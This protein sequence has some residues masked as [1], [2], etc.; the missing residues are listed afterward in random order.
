MVR[1]G[2]SMELNIGDVDPV[3]AIMLHVRGSGKVLPSILD[4]ASALRC[5]ALDCSSGEILRE[6]SAGSRDEFQAYR[7]QVVSP[8]AP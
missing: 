8:P 2:F 3:D 4:L 1:L 5:Y 6:G 7:D